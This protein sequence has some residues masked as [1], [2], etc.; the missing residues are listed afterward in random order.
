[1]NIKLV[2]VE[3]T[4]LIGEGIDFWVPE[5]GVGVGD[6]LGVGSLIL[7]MLVD[8][9]TTFFAFFWSVGVAM[10]LCF[11][12]R[13]FEALAPAPGDGSLIDSL[14]GDRVETGIIRISI[15]PSNPGMGEMKLSKDYIHIHKEL[16]LKEKY[17]TKR[18]TP[19]QDP[20]HSN[21]VGAL[22]FISQP[23]T[24][25]LKHFFQELHEVIRPT[26]LGGFLSRILSIVVLPPQVDL[27]LQR[28]HSTRHPMGGHTASRQ[29]TLFLGVDLVG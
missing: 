23:T 1:L 3:H 24:D 6:A 18:R 10:A 12:A 22:L 9:P 25:V 15:S 17:R 7:I 29:V 13:V 20:F 4:C 19:Y 8:L 16:D 26:L 14:L 11:P 28:N 5:G 2:A 27:L 21:M